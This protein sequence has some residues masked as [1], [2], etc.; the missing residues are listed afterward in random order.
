MRKRKKTSKVRFV[1]FLCFKMEKKLKL[2]LL[3]ETNESSSKASEE[4]SD[5][6]SDEGL[7]DEIDEEGDVSLDSKSKSKSFGR[8]EN[9]SVVFKR[10]IKT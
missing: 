5:E 7:G 9:Q 3:A 4:E 8:I 2:N 6:G 1:A 10:S